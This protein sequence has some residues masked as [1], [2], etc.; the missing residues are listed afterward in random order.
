MDQR[1]LSTDATFRVGPLINLAPLL[2]SLG[3]DPEPIFRRAGFGLEEFKDPDHRLPYLRGSQLLADC[4]AASGCEHLG[5]LLGQRAG[6]SHL[7]VVGFL[8]RAAETAEQALRALVEN[9]DLHDDAASVTLDIGADFTSLE[10]AL[11]IS[12]ASA[13]DQIYDLS[14]AIM[15]RIMAALCG[16]GWTASSVKLPRRRPADRSPYRRFFRTAVHFDATQCALMFPSYCLK[17]KP[18][19]ADQLLYQHLQEEARTL[20]GLQHHEILEELPAALRRGLL[21]EQFAAC[22]IAD[23]FG[24]HERTLH[25]RLRAAS[26]NFRKELDRARESVSQELLETTSLPVCDIAKA[27]GYADSSGFI[28]AFQRWSGTSPSSWRKRNGHRTGVPV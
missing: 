19:A 3:C 18:P 8:V 16:E 4:V 9:L 11:T 20:H 2:S 15:Y 25:R 22:Q 27:L 17:Q 26:T 23:T 5:L 7:G 21:A 10:F 13:V 6:P 1:Q 28:R 12:G 24:I 14:A